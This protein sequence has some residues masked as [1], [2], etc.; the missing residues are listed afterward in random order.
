MPRSAK[1]RTAAQTGPVLSLS[2]GVLSIT[3]PLT[4]QGFAGGEP[5]PPKQKPAAINLDGVTALDTAGALWLLNLTTATKAKLEGLNNTHHLLFKKVADAMGKEWQEPDT[6]HL[7]QGFFEKVGRA[8]VGAAQNVYEILSLLGEV[9]VAFAQIAVGQRAFRWNSFV[10]HVREAGLLALPIVMLISFLMSIVLAYQGVSQLSMFGAQRY[11]INL[12]AISILREMGGL[13]AAI[14]VAGRSGSSF[15]S[16]IGVMKIRE[17]VDA[18]SAVGLNPL[19]V[20]ILPRITA[21]IVVLPLL[22]VAAFAAGIMGGALMSV[23]TLG[24]DLSTYFR[25]FAE[26]TA[27]HTHWVGLVKAPVFALFI[28]IIS[29]RC[30]LR[31]GGSADSVGKQTTRAVVE[32]I[33]AVLV[34][35]AAFS[36]FFARIGW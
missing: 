31:V 7:K 1:A 17:E 33:F 24:V 13:L 21:L 36:I 4:L 27:S 34:I 23:A 29:C 5:T 32:G 6:S 11:A 25:L 8:G 26:A 20:M 3:G 10:R 2:G 16:E 18:M 12:V 14:M 15:T 28:G 19:D 35:D 9:S 22:T 30:G